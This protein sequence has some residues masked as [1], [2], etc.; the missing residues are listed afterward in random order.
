MK[1][2][3]LFLS[4]FSLI[5]LGFAAYCYHT[6]GPKTG[7]AACFAA[8]VYLLYVASLDCEEQQ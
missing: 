7:A 2:G 5:W 4:L 8:G 1:K 3:N 6:V